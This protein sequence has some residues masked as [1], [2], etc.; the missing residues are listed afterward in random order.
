MEN[1]LID[2]SGNDVLVTE[3][4]DLSGNDVSGNDTVINLYTLDNS[5]VYYP[6]QEYYDSLL[7]E[8]KTLHYIGTTLQALLLLLICVPKMKN[9]GRRT[10]NRSKKEVARNE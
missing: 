8:V 10:M 1:I 4:L 5:N 3:L 7:H 9:F 6:D 2:V